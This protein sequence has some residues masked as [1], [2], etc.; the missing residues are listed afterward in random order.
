MATKFINTRVQ[1]PTSLYGTH[2][3]DVESHSSETGVNDGTSVLDGRDRR[4]NPAQLVSCRHFTN[5]AVM[6][7]R[8]IR[9][10]NKQLELA[11]NFNNM[12]TD[13]LGIVDHKIV[14]AEEIET[15]QIENTTL[16]TSSAWRTTSGAA[17]GGV[18]LMLTRSAESAL[19]KV[20][21]CTP[22]I[23]VAH[24]SSG[25][26]TRASTDTT[27]IVNYAPVEGSPDADEHYKQLA[28]AITEVPRHNILIVM[29]DFNGHIGSADARHTYHS[30]TNQNGQRLLDL[31]EEANLV[32]TNTIFQK[33]PGKLWS[34]ISDMSDVK[35]Q[36]DYILVNR[37]W[38][39]SVKNV[40][41]YNSFSSIGSDHR[42][43]NAKIKLSLRVS[44]TPPKTRY[45]WSALRCKDLQQRYTVKIRN[46]YTELCTETISAT[47]RYDHLIQ[48][49]KEAAKE[50]L[51][52]K[53]TNKKKCLSTDPRVVE[54]RQNIQIAFT[55]YVTD[56]NTESQAKL[57]EEKVNLQ[58]IYDKI[59]EEELESMIRRVE[60][61]DDKSKHGERWRLINDISGRKTAKNGILKGKGRED[62]LKQW[63]EHFSNLLGSEPTVTGDP[64]EDIP[65]VLEIT[66]IKTGLFDHSE[67]AAAKKRSA[68]GKLPGPDGI[69]MEVLNRC[70]LDDIILDYA[71]NLII[72][73]DK[74]DQW[75]I[76]DLI[77]IPKQ[78]DLSD[79][80]NYRGIALSAVMAKLTN[81]MILNRIQPP[82]DKELR[83]NQNGFR[84][85]RSTAAHV[86]AL[87]R[88][89]EG[90]RRNNL[91]AI[92]T[93]V[94]FK[95][96]FDSIHRGKMMK[97]L[98]AYGV[99]DE[100]VTAIIKIYENTK[101]R[102]QT[103]DGETELFDILAGV[104]QGDTLAPFLFAIVLDY[105][106]RRA[107]NGHESE[108][109]FQIQRARSRRYTPT[110]ITDLDFADDIALISSEIDQA[111]VILSRLESEAKQVG[112]HLNAKKTEVMSFNQDAA[113]AIKSSAGNTLKVVSNFKYLG[114]WMQRTEKD[115]SI[116]KALAW[117]ACHKLKRIWSSSLKRSLKVRLFLATVESVLLFG[118]ETLDTNENAGKTTKWC[119]H[120][121]L[122]DGNKYIEETETHKLST[123]PGIANR[124]I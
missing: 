95:K 106:M 36:V 65:T 40:E 112:L 88:L 37:K 26:A 42:V 94:D 100:L 67:L 53:K 44:K 7:V 8:T 92:I 5:V 86:L 28:A 101:A 98:K 34:Y 79:T 70:D 85:G 117:S 91:K 124:L 97:I 1:V 120:P 82:I 46:K 39:N 21:K 76:I 68:V 20:E 13:I 24:F 107:I 33:K 74:P 63:Y 102:V 18:G 104:L 19:A 25:T 52:V 122:E 56:S 99:P 96:A 103:P 49:N 80:G 48:A 69:P 111:Q 105:V 60:N 81:K 118:S 55:E 51:P 3:P 59:I 54:A 16:I 47:E 22:R 108:L 29:G 57:Q 12:S 84:P 27:I 114:G 75:S 17:L 45:D 35:S 58:S 110:I 11:N 4:A 10:Q 2:H 115:F 109:G 93:F 66:N 6:N 62:R 50:L 41:A 119:V 121:T 9:L 73:E 15:H 116:R 64:D 72:N 89:I 77:P 90:V 38:R 61:A 113:P 78:G 87:R 30:V 23:I 43:I 71:N 32:I 123:L 14:H 31:A 83:P